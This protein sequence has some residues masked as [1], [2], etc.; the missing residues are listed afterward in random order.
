M[1][2]KELPR[3]LHQATSLLIEREAKDAYTLL[4]TK[5]DGRAYNYPL[6]CTAATQDGT[7]LEMGGTGGRA[8][9]SRQYVQV[10]ERVFA[11]EGHNDSPFMHGR[12]STKQLHGSAHDM[13]AVAGRELCAMLAS[14]RAH[15]DNLERYLSSLIGLGVG[16]TPSGDDFLVGVLAVV[17]AFGLNPLMENRMNEVIERLSEKTSTISREYLIAAVQGRFSRSVIDVVNTMS[18][19]PEHTSA[20]QIEAALRALFSHGSTSGTDSAAG[21]IE[22]M[23]AYQAQ[24]RPTTFSKEIEFTSF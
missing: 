24:R 17:K 9:P 4:L 6:M 5:A 1:S 7:I 8:L 22:M 16:L 12:S 20:T 18:A 15:P 11:L 19:Y 10:A 21:I 3:V 23:R 14:L 13:L 2:V